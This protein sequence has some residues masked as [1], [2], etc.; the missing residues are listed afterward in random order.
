APEAGQTTT[1]TYTNGGLTSLQEVANIPGHTAQLVLR[2]IGDPGDDGTYTI[3]VTA[4][5]HYSPTPGVTSTDFVTVIQHN[6]NLTLDPVLEFTRACDSFEVSVLNGPYDGYLWDN[7][8]HNPTTYI[9][10]SGN[11]GVTVN[12]NQCYKRVDSMIVVPKPVGF[13]L[14]GNLY[15]CPGE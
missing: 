8:S 15:L 10:D 2:G 9:T 14:V 3:N 13:N 7:L 5:D 11:F 4:S 6:P 12:P 1:I